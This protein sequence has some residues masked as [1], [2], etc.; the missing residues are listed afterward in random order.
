LNESF[1]FLLVYGGWW[2]VYGRNNQH[3][4]QHP[5]TNKFSINIL[6]Y[7]VN[8]DFQNLKRFLKNDR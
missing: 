5:N 4:C 2:M 1:H 8:K 6:I 3:L 7:L